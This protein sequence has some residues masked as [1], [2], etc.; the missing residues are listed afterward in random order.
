MRLASGQK[1]DSGGGD[2]V[3]IRYPSPLQGW[4]AGLEGSVQRRGNRLRVKVQLIDAE[5]GHASLGRALPARHGSISSAAVWCSRC[6]AG[7][8][9]ARRAD[10]SPPEAAIGGGLA[11]LKT[12]DRVRIDLNK[13]TADM[14]MSLTMNV[15]DEVPNRLRFRFEVSV[16]LSSRDSQCLSKHP[17]A[18]SPRT[19]LTAFAPCCV[20]R[21]PPRFGTSLCRSR[22][23]SR[24]ARNFDASNGR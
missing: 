18:L 7:Q 1:S 20:A 24:R 4:C 14:L 23:S 19:K 2:A 8:T 6:P 11:L 22:R 10:I 16:S 17:S 12:G 21:R 5:T 3:G 13:G 9:S 15:L